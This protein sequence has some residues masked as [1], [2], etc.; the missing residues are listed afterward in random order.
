MAEGKNDLL[1]MTKL[2]LQNFRCFEHKEV[3]FSEQ[4]NVLV[5]DNGSGKTAVLDALAMGLFSIVA[6]SETNGQTVPL[7]ARVSEDDIRLISRPSKGVP[8][9]ERQ[10]PA[11][12]ACETIVFDSPFSWMVDGSET[13]DE[14]ARIPGI[15]ARDLMDRAQ[16]SVSVPLPAIAYYGTDRLCDHSLQT[17]ETEGPTSRSS[18]YS[19]CLEALAGERRFLPWF[20]TLEL[21]QLQ[22]G[23]ELTPLVSVKRAVM[24]CLGN[25]SNVFWHVRS[26]ELTIQW[27][28]GSS[29]PYRMLSHGQRNMLAMVA[30]IAWRTATLNPNL[31]DPVAETPGIVLIDEIDLHLH[32]KWQRRVVDDLRRT[33][34]LVQFIATT[35]SPFIVQGLRPGE[36]INLDQSVKSEYWKESPE[37]IVE[38]EMGVPLP[39]RSERYQQMAKAAEE[40]YRLLRQGKTADEDEKAH[41]RARL[42]ELTEPFDDDIAFS[43]FLR[44]ERLAAGLGE[45]SQ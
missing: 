15:L 30:D 43:T 21:A 25:C 45:V 31:D 33:F 41:L 32:P 9:V 17:D 14:R 24:S 20:K 2:T 39:Q 36:L 3:E 19:G 40:Y 34:P 11:R 23:T 22:E 28:D 27:A 26:N 7:H 4:F 38:K 35:H 8:I 16:Q 44:M 37:D 6:I 42:D 18:G 13:P 10:H 29:M 1:R 12:V 5:G